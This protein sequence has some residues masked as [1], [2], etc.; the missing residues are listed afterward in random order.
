V[1]DVPEGM[2]T[3]EATHAHCWPT[4]EQIVARA[5]AV[6]TASASGEH[7]PAQRLRAVYVS[8]N[9][10]PEWVAGL[11]ALL[12]ADGWESVGSSV[13][14]Q[15]AKDEQA[16][17]QAIDMSVLVAAESFIGVGV[18]FVS[19]FFFCAVLMRR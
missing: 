7:F 8:T 10:K 11:A 15:L 19:S 13:D 14:M 9:G 16:V 6:R 12:R 5:R 3:Q 17:A 1:I 4:P 2:T 18:R